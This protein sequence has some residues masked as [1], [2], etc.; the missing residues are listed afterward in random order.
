[1]HSLIFQSLVC[2]LALF[3]LL[4]GIKVIKSLGN[5]FSYFLEQFECKMVLANITS[6][7]LFTAVLIS[8]II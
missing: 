2:I 6:K 5:F 3:M 8:L 1:M 7:F 4:L